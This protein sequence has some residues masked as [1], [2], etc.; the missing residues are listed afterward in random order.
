MTITLYDKLAHNE[1]IL[2][3][4]P[5]REG[6]GTITQDVAK[7]HHPITLHNAPTWTTLASGLPCLTLNG[8]TEYLQCLSASCADLDFTS[9]DYSIGGWVYFTGIAGASDQTLMC[10]FLLDNDGWELYHYENLILTLRHH[11]STGASARTGAYSI[12]WS[13][14]KWWFMGVSREGGSAQFYRGDASSFSALTTSITAGGLIDP[15]SCSQN[16][17]MGTDITGYND[18]KGPMWRPRVWDVALTEGDWMNIHQLEKG[19][20]A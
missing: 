15:E 19:W 9:G 17:F 6:V 8:T 18:Y 4:L 20:F 12:N 5:F 1:D 7:P 11:H 14:D 2:L 3:D 13:F 16:L 10:R